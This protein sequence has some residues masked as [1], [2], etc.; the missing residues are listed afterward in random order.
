VP[1]TRAISAAAGLSSSITDISREE[2]GAAVG[3]HKFRQRCLPPERFR[4]PTTPKPRHDGADATKV[5]T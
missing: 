5:M 1:T 4:T 3:V 2:S